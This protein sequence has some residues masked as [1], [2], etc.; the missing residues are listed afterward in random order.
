MINRYYNNLGQY[1]KQGKVL[2][3]QGP[4]QVGKTTLVKN[5]LE[6]LEKDYKYLYLTGDSIETMNIFSSQ[7]KNIITNFASNI[8]LI[9][10]DEAQKIPNIG[11][12]LKILIDSIPEIKVITTGSSSFD[13]I[14]QV[15]EPLVGR[16][17]RL[18]LYP[19]S[20][21]ELKT[22]YPNE[23][24]LNQQLD[25]LLIY[26]L[27][28][29]VLNFE[30]DEQRREYLITFVDMYLLKDVLEYSGIKGSQFLS[31]LLKL[32][33]FQIGSLVSL[34]ELSNQ[35][36]V[37]INTVQK[38]LDLLEK[39][40]IIFSLGGYNRNLKKEVTSK[41]K[42][43]FY[44]L[45]IR[46]ALISNFNEIGVRDDIGAIWENFLVMERLKKQEYGKIYANNYFWRTWDQKEVDFVEERDGKLYGFEFKWGK[47]R[48]N[49]TKLFT[50]T[51]KEASI[52]VINRDNYLE[53]VI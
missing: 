51:Y 50:D 45:G 21:L 44:D 46:N 4:R 32:L 7:S 19:V 2:I 1:I 27:Y 53:F 52:E 33:A 24:M 22:E 15:G 5:Y 35:L 39:N 9:V 40:Y 34:T 8:D 6:T 47:A 23:Y 48:S 18:M 16:S 13:L 49:S 36:Q 20:L 38:Y 14:K 17:N 12:G 31:D 3:L 29:E 41:K 26:G 37:N 43:Y 25:K 10:I 30:T 42:Y 28:P 11:L